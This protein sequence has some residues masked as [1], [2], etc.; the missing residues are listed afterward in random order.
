M[1]NNFSKNLAYLRQVK[2]LSKR[3]LAQKTG[4][5]EMAIGYYEHGKRNPTL[6]NLIKIADFFDIPIDRLIR[7]DVANEKVVEKVVEK[8]FEKNKGAEF[9]K[10]LLITFAE[11]MKQVDETNQNAEFVFRLSPAD[12]AQVSLKEE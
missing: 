12:D 1:Q 9:F 10:E 8:N 11:T 3:E 7:A 5:S 2:N 4:I 6:E